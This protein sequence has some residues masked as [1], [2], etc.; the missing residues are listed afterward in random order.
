VTINS[1]VGIE[2]YLHRKPV[3]LCGQSDFHHIAQVA[4]NA[5]E[6]GR[7]LKQEKRA[8]AYDKYVYW[9]YA[10]QCL[11]TVEPGLI[12]RFLQR[13]TAQGYEV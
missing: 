8:K 1:A 10:Q 6:L 13:V 7:F 11:S 3:I 5:Q 9:Y 12:D 2:A 4:H